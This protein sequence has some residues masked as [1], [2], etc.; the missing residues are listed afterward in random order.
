M[1]LVAARECA[2]QAVKCGCVGA[3]NCGQLLGR[4]EA[5]REMVSEAQ[6]RGCAQEKGD[7]ESH[8]HLHELGVGRLR[9]TG[10]CC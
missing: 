8:N 6:L 2:Q 3:G 5:V 1:R 7:G 10:F 4:L 9:L